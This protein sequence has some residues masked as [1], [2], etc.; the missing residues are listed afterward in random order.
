MDRGTVYGLS[1]LAGSSKPIT[2]LSAK[3]ADHHHQPDGDDNGDDAEE[4]EDEDDDNVNGHEET[5]HNDHNDE[6]ENV[7]ITYN[8]HSHLS[9]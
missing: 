9:H 6:V 1:T 3:E 8:V 4:G 7:A 2:Y 5:N